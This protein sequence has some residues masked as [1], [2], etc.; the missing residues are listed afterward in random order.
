LR[1]K[2]E[3]DIKHA[4]ILF[5][6]AVC[7]SFIY[8]HIS[9]SGIAV[10]GQWNPD[11]GVVSALPQSGGIDIS[12]EIN[13]PETVKIIVEKRQRLILDVRPLDFYEMGHLPGALSFPLENFKT[14]IR[15]L[16]EIADLHRPILVYCS[17]FDCS[18]S[19]IFAEK[20]QKLNY[21]DVKVY[22]GG[23]AQWQEMGYEIEK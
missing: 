11:K 2:N 18:A 6:L 12:I 19:H 15:Q 7:L 14:G 21:T 17:G 5:F 20:L 3:K 22:S 1:R 8:N 23:F 13:N 9:E 10:F 4:L 16:K